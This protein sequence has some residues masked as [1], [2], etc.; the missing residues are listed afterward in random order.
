MKKL[1]EQDKKILSIYNELPFPSIFYEMDNL[2]YINSLDS[3]LHGYCDRLLNNFSIK[4]FVIC[5]KEDALIEE[6]FKTVISKADKD[7]DDV[8]R[9][10]YMYQLAKVIINKYHKELWRR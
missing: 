2:N 9:Y 7:L 1:S 3:L 6:E 5:E 8:L 4:D 10:Y